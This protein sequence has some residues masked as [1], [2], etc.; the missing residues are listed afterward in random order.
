[1][2]NLHIYVMKTENLHVITYE[3]RYINIV[4]SCNFFLSEFEEIKSCIYRVETTNAEIGLQWFW[5]KLFIL[6]LEETAL[7]RPRES[8]KYNI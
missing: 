6:L 8:A 5:Y 1:M 3:R 4:N 7:L 2:Y